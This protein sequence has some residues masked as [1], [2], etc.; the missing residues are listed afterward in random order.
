MGST[1]LHPALTFC[2][3]EGLSR[4]ALSVCVT[5]VLTGLGRG[6]T[7]G[8]SLPG[9]S[10]A[11]RKPAGT[12]PDLRGL[13]GYS[14]DKPHGLQRLPGSLGATGPGPAFPPRGGCRA[15]RSPG[16]ETAQRQPPHKLTLVTAPI[17]QH[18]QEDMH[19]ELFRPFL[20]SF[21]HRTFSK[22]LSTF[23]LTATNKTRAPAFTELT[24]P[25]GRQTALNTVSGS[26]GCPEEE[27]S[28][29]RHRDRAVPG[30]LLEGG[31]V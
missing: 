22:Q 3:P 4:T 13:Q 7:V 12:R 8:K 30:R 5:P 16:R 15:D 23:G 2:D 24:V 14:P 27:R 10:E 17:F 1:R 28:R 18:G 9:L 11:L 6:E 29:V 31:G 20:R 26:S 21:L 19:A 25:S